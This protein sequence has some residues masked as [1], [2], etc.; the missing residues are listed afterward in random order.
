METFSDQQCS[1][2]M[3]EGM[4]S[5]PHMG[6]LHRHAAAG[7]LAVVFLVGCSSGGDNHA[8]RPDLSP[9]ELAASLAGTYRLVPESVIVPDSFFGFGPVGRLVSAR[10]AVEL[11]ASGMLSG[12]FSYTY[13]LPGEIAPVVTVEATVYDASAPVVTV[14]GGDLWVSAFVVSG[15]TLGNPDGGYTNE[16]EY[17][18]SGTIDATTGVLELGRTSEEP[19]R[20]VRVP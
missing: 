19:L 11:D 15:Y 20:F 3:P 2:R 8:T 4:R 10:G 7:L 6:H 12:A 16:E 17:S 14:T 1:V 5:L 18:L 13:E 9:T